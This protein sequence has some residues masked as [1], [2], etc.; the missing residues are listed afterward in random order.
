MKTSNKRLGF[1]QSLIAMAVLSA[2]GPAMAQEAPVQQS[3]VSVGIG[4]ATGD[5]QDRARWGLY[6]GMREDSA[7]GLFDFSFL[8]RD[9]AAGLWTTV[10]GRNLFLDTREVSF[11]T[12]KLGDWKVAA[13]YSE[14]LR[15]EPRTIN[16]AMQ[17]AGT[18]KPE[19]VYLAAPGTGSDVNLTLHR[20]AFTLSGAKWFGGDVQVEASYKTEDKDGARIF[21][22]GFACSGTWVAAGA[23]TSSTNQWELLLLPEPIDATTQQAEAKITYS[24]GGLLLTGGYY[25][26]LYTNRN[27]NLSPTVP[28]TLNNPLGQ[29]RTVDAG[30]RATLAMPM[31]L[32]ADSQAHQFYLSGN[33][34]FTPSTAANFKYAYTHATQN[35]DFGG[36]GFYLAPPGR[37]NLGGEVNT[38]LAQAGISSRPVSKLSLLANVRYEKKDNKTPIDVYNIEGTETFTNA[39]GKKERLSSKIEASYQLPEGYRATAGFDWD[40]VDHGEFTPTNQVAGLSGLRQ[41]TKEQGYRL[42]LRK[43]MS[44]SLTGSLQYT[45]SKREGDSPWLKPQSPGVIEAD[46]SQDCV[47]PTGGVN[48]CIYN[49]TGIFPFIFQDRKRDKVRAMVSWVPTDALSLQFFVDDGKDDYT[50]P[51][52]KGLD[53]SKLR[54]YSFDANYRVNDDWNVT[55]YASRGETTVHVAHSTGYMAALKDTADGLGIAVK[56]K[57][58]ERLAIKADLTYLKDNNEYKQDLDASASAA[59]VAF[60]AAS[61]GLPDVEYKLLRFTLTGDYTIDRKSLVRVVLGYEK[62]KFNEWAWQ[63]NGNSFLYSDNTTVSAKENQNVTFVG[64]SYTYR[65]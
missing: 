40:S 49:R 7:Y 48:N 31:A 61:G 62:S 46:D 59:N 12:R 32:P 3:S 19:V 51:S 56:G 39:N 10:E 53:D 43:N 22:K 13:G 58:S 52:T 65:W 30:L 17:G 1:K 57:A 44:D 64:A 15:S 8:S 34:R 16:T 45:Y 60:L 6:N 27:G 28:G 2:F 29:A 26:S 20:K 18:T 33:Y 11:S 23:C 24:K 54:M 5:Q 37:S 42:E 63:W 25:G 50:A 21:G 36:T 55:G 9:A 35:E 4:G 41:K 14:I 38:T 47:P